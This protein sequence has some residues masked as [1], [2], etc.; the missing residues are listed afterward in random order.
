MSFSQ[1]RRMLPHV[2]KEHLASIRDKFDDLM[3]S[4]GDMRNQNTER[5]LKALTVY[6]LKG[7]YDAQENHEDDADTE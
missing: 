3:V 4:V 5:L 2:R 6:I 1:E 7:G